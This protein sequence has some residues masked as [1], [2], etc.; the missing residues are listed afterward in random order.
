M[1]KYLLFIIL[2][3]GCVKS[4]F[5]DRN[6]K[7]TVER[8]DGLTTKTVVPE[9]GMISIVTYGTDTLAVLDTYANIIV[10]KD[11]T[12]E[13]KLRVSINEKPLVDYRT[14]SQYWQA[15]A[16]EDTRIGD[17]D[18]N[19]L[20]IHVKNVC[21]RPWNKDSIEQSIVIQPIALGG[22][23]NISLGFILS[24]FTEHIVSTNVRKDLFNDEIGFINTDNITIRYKLDKEVL[25][26]YKLKKD[27]TPWVAWFIEV[28]GKRQYAV[29]SELP[30]KVYDMLNTEGMPYGLVKYSTFAY[31]KESISM[32]MAY[33]DFSGWINGTK[34]GIGTGVKEHLFD[35]KKLWDYQDI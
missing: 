12:D 3:V 4:P 28:G 8:L 19:D 18:Y 21:D 17:Y 20:V 26:K 16:F 11:L 9:K 35:S 6:L 13:E 2:L 25:H 14:Y 1:Y 5:S 31:P 32:F 24:D 22:T 7:Q 15:V 29:S 33:P 23:L 30:N 34:S 10:P 27:A